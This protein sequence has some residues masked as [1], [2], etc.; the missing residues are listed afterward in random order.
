[1]AAAAL[2]GLREVIEGLATTLV[3]T[4]QAGFQQQAV[5]QASQSEAYFAQMQSIIGQQQQNMG[6]QQ[7]AFAQQ[8]QQQSFEQQQQTFTQQRVPAEDMPAGDWPRSR[9]KM[10]DTRQFYVQDFQPKSSWLNWAHAFKI[11]LKSQYLP[12]LKWIVEAEA[13]DFVETSM[14]EDDDYD[15]LSAEIYE[16]LTKYCHEPDAASI[17]RQVDDCTGFTAWS[18]LVARFN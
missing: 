15:R 9:R 11:A 7:Q 5:M 4:M 8:Q 10:L 3:G 6:Q 18:R 2:A 16:L 14:H 13:T 12:G 17:I 1:M